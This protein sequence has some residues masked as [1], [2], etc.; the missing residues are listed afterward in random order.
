[1]PLSGEAL[2][3]ENIAEQPGTPP[4]RDHFEKRLRQALTGID[5][6][7]YRVNIGM[8]CWTFMLRVWQRRTN[9]QNARKQWN[10]IRYAGTVIP[11]VAAGAGG[12]LVS[13]IH[14]TA[15]TAIGWVALAGGVLGAAVNAIRPGIEYGVDL[16]KAARFEQL[17]WD[18]YNYAMTSMPS[19]S[20]E[21]IAATLKGFSEQ[22]QEIA[23]LSGATTATS[24]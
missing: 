20:R 14:G 23:V 5:D 6:I 7:E 2:A 15:G 9:A 3:H 10:P 1:M 17:Y 12:S 8:Q 21:S 19:D 24:S 13:H 18:V 4:A 22:M 11:V 16:A